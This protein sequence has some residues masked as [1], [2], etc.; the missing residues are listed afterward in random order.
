MSIRETILHALERCHGLCMDDEWDREN[1][2]EVIADCLYHHPDAQLIRSAFANAPT[3]GM[4]LSAMRGL[5]GQR[6]S[7][8]LSAA[9]RMAGMD[10]VTE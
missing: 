8:V 7:L 5:G 10:G 9:A 1:A 4:R 6:E 2:A 3:G